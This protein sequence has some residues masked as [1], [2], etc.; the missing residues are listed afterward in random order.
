MKI[1]GV[2]LM[3]KAAFACFTEIQKAPCSKVTVI[4]G[5]GNNA[6]DGLMVAALCHMSGMSV[7]V[8]LCCPSVKLAQDSQYMLNHAKLL[9]VKI[10]RLEVV[11]TS[12]I[13]DLSSSDTVVDGIGV[14][15][16]VEG[17]FKAIINAVNQYAH[18]ALSIDVPSGVCASTGKVFNVAIIAN[19]TVSFICRK[20]G[21]YTGVA[22]DYVGKRVFVPLVNDVVEIDEIPVAELLDKSS[23]AAYLKL[24]PNKRVIN[25]GDRGHLAFIAGD[26]GMF[27]AAVLAAVAALKS[28]AGRVSIFTRPDN[29]CSSVNAVYPEIMCHKLYSAEAFLDQKDKFDVIALGCGLSVGLEWSRKI[30]PELLNIDKTMVIDAGAL[31]FLSKKHLCFSSPRIITPHE[32]EAARMLNMDAQSVKNDRISAVKDLARRFDVSVLLK[33]VRQLTSC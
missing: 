28:G 17:V 16:E 29:N 24:L 11:D 2:D 10:K 19:K 30:I 8:Y 12:C 27:G 26:K 33:R 31:D 6:G 23:I 9:G 7:T 15:K 21:L 3:A 1:N 4:C 20:V 32:G 25:K 14:N 22:P 5:A 18:Y 13:E